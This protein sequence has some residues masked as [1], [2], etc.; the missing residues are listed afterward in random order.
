MFYI[1]G[2]I[3]RG[4]LKGYRIYDTE[5][6]IFTDLP[7]QQII[8]SEVKLENAEVKKDKL[9]GTNG[10]LSRYGDVDY[11][12]KSVPVIITEIYDSGKVKY[13]EV[14]FHDKR[15]PNGQYPTYFDVKSLASIASFTGLSNGKLVNKNNSTYI[16]VIKGEYNRKFIKIEYIN[17]VEGSAFFNDFITLYEQNKMDLANGKEK[18]E[19]IEKTN[20]YV[21][22]YFK[23]TLGAVVFY[24]RKHGQ[25]TIITD[26]YGRN[27]N[28]T[29]TPKF[30]EKMETT[31]VEAQ[32]IG[33]KQGFILVA[34]IAS[35]TI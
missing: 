12:E 22:D 11:T 24:W 9:V 30:I 29:C 16:S 20:K 19:V 31:A 2:R 1:V 26:I 15:T 3:N 8:N 17:E 7:E 23:Y 13:Y 28:K 14:V 4:N 6:K 34:K 21:E 27:I 32:Q 5:K 18:R 33:F 10:A 25:R 35:T